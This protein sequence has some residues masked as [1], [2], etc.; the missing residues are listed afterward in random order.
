MAEA[1]EAE[2]GIR[3]K[4]QRNLASYHKNH[5]FMTF[6]GV[7][8]AT[9]LAC[10]GYIDQDVVET[11]N[12]FVAYRTMKT[13]R[14]PQ[15][16]GLVRGPRLSRRALAATQGDDMPDVRGVFHVVSEGKKAREAAKSMQK[17]FLWHE[18][19]WWTAF[20][21]GKT[22]AGDWWEVE[23]QRLAVLQERTS[24]AG[25]TNIKICE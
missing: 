13:G 20:H 25:R 2:E 19:G 22:R 11:V 24:M 7:V 16:E 21:K 23:S 17:E 5:L 8:W 14:E 1:S 6:G 4:Y 3:T 9:L 15:K 10:L 18:Q 12:S